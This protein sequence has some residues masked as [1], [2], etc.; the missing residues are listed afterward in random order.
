M[1]N[2]RKNLKLRNRY[3]WLNVA[4]LILDAF[5]LSTV[6]LSMRAAEIL[7]HQVT[8]LIVPFVVLAL[9]L[10][11]LSILL[12]LVDGNKNKEILLNFRKK[13]NLLFIIVASVFELGA[14]I[15]FVKLM[16]D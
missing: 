9:L 15:C 4:I 14:I 16:S 7:D 2:N 1:E 12:S 8:Y 6:F 3:L 13:I 11:V 10:P 5:I